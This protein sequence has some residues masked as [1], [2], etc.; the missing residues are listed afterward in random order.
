M[1]DDD[2]DYEAARERVLKRMKKRQGFY[3]H[4]AW[5]VGMNLIFWVIWMASGGWGFPWPLVITL[6]WGIGLVSDA[7]ETYFQSNPDIQARREQAIAREIE[8]E[9]ARSLDASAAENVVL[10]KPKRKRV[11]HLAEDGELVYDDE[12]AEAEDEPIR[13]TSRRDS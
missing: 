12:T 6:A 13:R 3:E 7:V 8:R 10:E 1:S 5:Y 9:R 2:Q 11:A 4:L